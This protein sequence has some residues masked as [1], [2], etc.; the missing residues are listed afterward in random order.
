M[1]SR[2]EAVYAVQSE[3]KERPEGNHTCGPRMQR[4]P[5]VFLVPLDT[6]FGVF[7]ASVFRSKIQHIW[8]PDLEPFWEGTPGNPQGGP[9]MNEN[10]NGIPGSLKPCFEQSSGFTGALAWRFLRLQGI[11]STLSRAQRNGFESFWE[12]LLLFTRGRPRQL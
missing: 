6:T 3:V 11:I 10:S 12:V 7:F 2:F 4:R 9:K 1:W 5:D 8:G